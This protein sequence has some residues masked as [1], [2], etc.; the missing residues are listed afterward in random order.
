MDDYNDGVA[1]G[2]SLHVDDYNDGYDAGVLFADPSCEWSYEVYDGSG[3]SWGAYSDLSGVD[4]SGVD[5]SGV[6]LSG[7]DLTGADLSDVDL[8]GAIVTADTVWTDVTFDEDTIC[9]DGDLAIEGKNTYENTEYICFAPGMDLGGTAG[10]LGVGADCYNDGDC[11]GDEEC[12]DAQ[13][14][15]SIYGYCEQQGWTFTSNAVLSTCSLWSTYNTIM[16]TCSF[17]I[18][19]AAPADLSGMEL[20]RV[21]FTSQGRKLWGV[22]FA[23]ADLTEASLSSGALQETN[24]AGANLTGATLLSADLSNADLTGADFTNANLLSVR[25]DDAICPDGNAAGSDDDCCDQLDI[26]IDGDGAIDTV[27]ASNG[28]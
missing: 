12:Q 5:L 28:C 20:Q 2:E 25:W 26:D 19:R 23:G 15:Q 17:S 8:T 6:D 24:F 27:T 3:C 11:S 10:G 13:E 1:Y 22:N 4:L 16:P 21:R 7:V 14:M 18:S 9:V